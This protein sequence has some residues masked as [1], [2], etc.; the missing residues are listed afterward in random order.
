M[1]EFTEEEKNKIILNLNRRLEISRSYIQRYCE[2][3]NVLQHSKRI[4]RVKKELDDEI[5]KDSFALIIE[6]ERKK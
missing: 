3:R 2:T 6:L 4:E 1:V 5:G